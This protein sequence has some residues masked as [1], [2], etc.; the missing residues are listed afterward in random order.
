M[1]LDRGVYALATRAF[2]AN[3]LAFAAIA[4][5]QAA[6]QVIPPLHSIGAT[7]LASTLASLLQIP[8]FFLALVTLLTGGAGAGAAPGRFWPFVLRFL[9]LGVP[10]LLVLALFDDPVVVALLLIASS[11]AMM[12]LFGTMLPDVVAGNGGGLAAALARGRRSFGAFLAW[13]LQGPALTLFGVGVAV[14]VLAAVATMAGIGVRVGPEGG[15][16]LAPWFEGLVAILGTLGGA[17]VTALTAAV[18]AKCWHLGG[19]RAA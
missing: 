17:Y 9:L 19:G 11:I 14:S 3:Y 1:D 15:P 16:L 5:A 10:P 2:R 7:L 8:L 13:T 18:L 12:G 6:L 4:M